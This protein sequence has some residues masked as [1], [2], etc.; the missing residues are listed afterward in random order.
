[1]GSFA[2]HGST[3]ALT[4]QLSAE[5]LRRSGLPMR[6]RRDASGTLPA[7]IRSYRAEHDARASHGLGAT[8]LWRCWLSAIT[9]RRI[10]FSVSIRIAA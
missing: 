6:L 5:S 8:T 9:P 3:T 7:R 2:V 4:L 1:M 10:G